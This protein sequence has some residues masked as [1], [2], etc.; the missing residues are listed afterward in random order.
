MLLGAGC[1][2]S[3]DSEG[4]SGSDGPA[5]TAADGGSDGEGGGALAP[6][7]TADTI[8]IGYAY[9][10]FGDLVSKGLSTEGWGDQEL[11]FQTFV[12]DLNEKGGINGRMVKV[13]FAP[14][15]P[16]GTEVAEAACLKLPRRPV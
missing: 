3:S 2:Q 10:D 5:T 6:G 12:D 16:L 15:T 1:T 11:A 4:S 14:Y 9:L 8:K 7:V 13:V